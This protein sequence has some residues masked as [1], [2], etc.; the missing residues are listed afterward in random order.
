MSLIEDKKYLK[1]AVEQAKKSV[2][3]GGFP[4]GSVVVKNDEIISEGVSL[5]RKLNDPTSH[6]ETSSIRKAC[7]KLETRDLSGATLYASLEPCLMCFS[8]SNWSGISRIVFGCQKTA[9]MVEKVYYEGSNNLVQINGQNSRKIELVLI[10]DFEQE[11]LELIKD[12][13]RN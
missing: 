12:W 8:V 3:E 4:A 9:E 7:K 13:E 11:M 6:A 1:L 5:G 10:S 2:E